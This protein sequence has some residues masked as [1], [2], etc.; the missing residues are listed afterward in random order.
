ML[1]M[2]AFAHSSL[3][4]FHRNDNPSNKSVSSQDKPWIR[5]T[6]AVRM[7]TAPWMTSPIILPFSTNNE[8]VRKEETDDA[9]TGGVK[10]GR[11]KEAMKKILQRVVRLRDLDPPVGEIKGG[12]E[13]I[14]IE[15]PLDLEEAEKERKR[16]DG[17]LPWA[18]ANKM[19]AVVF[20][21]MKKEKVVTLAE[22]ILSEEE[23]ERLRANARRIRVW[24]KA[25]KAGVT[26]DVVDDIKRIW[27][28]DELALVRFVQPLN[29]NM[30]RAREILEV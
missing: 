1:G 20:R 7:P 10:G 24:V 15:F 29:R 12:V 17:R 13:E 26:Q 19:P 2:P 27:R 16:R 25:K 5:T 28:N 22:R 8:N 3:R 30:D 21:R 14:E 6:E 11:S 18:T 23:L 9:L 4:C